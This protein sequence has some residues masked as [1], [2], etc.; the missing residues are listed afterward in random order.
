[1]ENRLSP[2]LLGYCAIVAIPVILIHLGLRRRAWMGFGE[3]DTYRFFTPAWFLTSFLGAIGLSVA[4]GSQFRG[5]GRIPA[6]LSMFLLLFQLMPI[7]TM[8]VPHIL[9]PTP[10]Q[11]LPRWMVHAAWAGVDPNSPD[12][13]LHFQK[14]MKEWKK[15]GCPEPH[16]YPRLVEEQKKRRLGYALKHP[17]YL[18]W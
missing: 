12:E 8:F 4:V 16:P 10:R 5:V 2:Y 13:T 15:A 18:L 9:R 11:L 17:K 3:T 6:A 1:M 7:V 14:T